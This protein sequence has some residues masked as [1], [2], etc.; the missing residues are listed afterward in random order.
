MRHKV[1]VEIGQHWL[2]ILF[3]VFK[4]KLCKFVSRYSVK[5]DTVHSP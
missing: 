5:G 3:F 4:G 1:S 2:V